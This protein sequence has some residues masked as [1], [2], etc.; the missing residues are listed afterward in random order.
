MYFRDLV[1]AKS[2]KVCE[3]VSGKFCLV[4]PWLVCSVEPSHG[5]LPSSDDVLELLIS[6]GFEFCERITKMQ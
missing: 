3:R 5:Y 6:F 4:K 2:W 1:A